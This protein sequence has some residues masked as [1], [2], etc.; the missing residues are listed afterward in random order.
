MTDST[1]KPESRVFELPSATRAADDSVF[2]ELV[3]LLNCVIVILRPDRSVAYLNPFAEQFTGHSAPDVADTDLL[4]LLIPESARS[5]VERRFQ[6]ALAGNEVS[7][8][9]HLL[10]TKRGPVRWVLSSFRSIHDSGGQPAVL[11]MSQDVTV[12]RH[13]ERELRQR[14]HD[15]G[16]RV[17]ELNCLFGLSKLVEDPELDVDGIC[18]GLVEILPQ[19]WQYPQDTCARVVFQGRVYRTDNFRVTQWKQT[20]SIEVYEQRLGAIEIFYLEEKRSAHE[21]P[22]LVEERRLL[23]AL[24]ERM[25]RIAEREQIEAE[26]RR[27]K[28]FAESLVQTAPAIVL[29]LD[30]EGHIL[31]INRYMEEFSGYELREVQGEN[32]LSTFVPNA[33][34][35]RM[36]HLA[37]PSQMQLTELIGPVRTKNGLEREVEWYTKTLMDAEEDVVG[38]L[39]VG[40]D[41]T[42]RRRLEKEIVDISTRE[43]QRI[44]Q[45]LHDG[46]GQELTGLGY[47]AQMLYCDLQQ[48]DAPETETANQL[49]DGVEKA[50]EQTRTIARGLV[51]VEIDADGLLNSLEQLADQTEQRFGIACRFYCDTPTLIDDTATAA[52]LFRIVR[53]AV[54]NATKHARA[55]RIT[56]EAQNGSDSLVFSIRDDGVGMP[57]TQ[58]SSDGMGLRIMQHRADVIGAALSVGPADGGGTLV[59]CTIPRSGDHG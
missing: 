15:L 59:T 8:I 2:R 23:N 5:E 31:R 27:E 46:L 29:V 7:E 49:A 14:T 35:E 22:F 41:I 56:I 18:A 33:A 42:Q 36:R 45:D 3:E 57:T 21:G 25:G 44:G 6:S 50:L 38:V 9:E 26:L 51:P 20:C 48:R 30:P 4:E 19:G 34:H 37:D 58:E 52:Q 1:Q 40:R 47:M 53:E 24:A 10:V 39:A 17:K 54:N 28:D 43:Q 13:A 55:S 11:L 12:H 32:W 16:E